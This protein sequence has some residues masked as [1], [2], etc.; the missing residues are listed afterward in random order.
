V[1][2]LPGKEEQNQE[3][4]SD[5]PLQIDDRAINAD[6]CVSLEEITYY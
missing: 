1:C 6:E 3:A 2:S 4:E 5:R